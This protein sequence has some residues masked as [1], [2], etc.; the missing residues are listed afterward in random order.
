MDKNTIITAVIIFLGLSLMIIIGKF[1]AWQ[2]A[3]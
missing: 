1:I 2:T 3:G